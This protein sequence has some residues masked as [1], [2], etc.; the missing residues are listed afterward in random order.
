M[1]KATNE[2]LLRE[3]KRGFSNTKKYTDVKVDD[4]ARMVQ[5]GFDGVKGEMYKGFSDMKEWQRLADG[6]F[7][8]LEHEL[9]SIKK[10]LENVI[11]RHE[12]EIIKERVKNLEHRLAA[13]LGK[14]K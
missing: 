14:K 12:F 3:V 11:Y 5:G 2:Q 6:K 13:A 10:D 9:L 7:D 4:L 8:V 1:A